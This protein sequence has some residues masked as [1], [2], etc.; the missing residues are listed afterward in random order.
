MQKFK[1]FSA[2]T[3]RYITRK[4]GTPAPNILYDDCDTFISI[5]LMTE[6]VSSTLQNIAMNASLA[7]FH[8]HS[9]PRTRAL[10]RYAFCHYIPHIPANLGFL[11]TKH[12]RLI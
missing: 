2:I 1:Y 6:A 7:L 5:L 11:F 10:L 3:V 8:W 12:D 4:V 9:I